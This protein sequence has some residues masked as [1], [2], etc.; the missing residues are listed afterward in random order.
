MVAFD[1]RQHGH[2]T[3]NTATAAPATPTPE[4]N[5]RSESAHD[6]GMLR[7]NL[8]HER[9]GLENRVEQ[10]NDREVIVQHS[11]IPTRAEALTKEAP[12]HSISQR[13]SVSLDRSAGLEQH[14]LQLGRELAFTLSPRELNALRIEIIPRTLLH[15]AKALEQ[16]L[17][18]SVAA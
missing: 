17:T 5:L 13:S 2:N 7:A 11:A 3:Q 4:L 15:G 16:Q 8:G 12:A 14:A 9:K 10:R 1:D 18:Q 6:T